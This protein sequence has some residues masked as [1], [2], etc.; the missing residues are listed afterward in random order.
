MLKM[1]TLIPFSDPRK[2]GTDENASLLDKDQVRARNLVFE[3]SGHSDML[4][5]L[6]GLALNP[7]NLKAP[8]QVQKLR[9][10]CLKVRKILFAESV[11]STQMKRK[12]EQLQEDT[13]SAVAYVSAE[14]ESDTP[15]FKKICEEKTS[16]ASSSVNSGDSADDNSYHL[17]CKL[18]STGSSLTLEYRYHEKPVDTNVTIVDG[19]KQYRYHE[20]PV[21][22]DVTFVDGAKQSDLYSTDGSRLIETDESV[23]GLNQLSPE[24]LNEPTMANFDDSVHGPEF[25]STDE[26]DS[27][28][29]KALKLWIS[30]GDNPLKSVS[31]EDINGST[32]KSE[33]ISGEDEDLKLRKALKLWLSNGRCLPKPVIPTGSGFQAEIPEWTGSTNRGNDDLRWLGTQIWPIKG[34]GKGNVVKEVGKGRPD[35]CSCISPRSA[36][37]VKRHIRE[38]SICLQSEIG[39]A[40]LSWKFDEMGE[41]VSKSWKVKEQ[42]AFKSLVKMNP[43]SNGTC[44]WE[45]ALKRFPSKCQKR[46]VSYYYNVFIPR[47]MSL[48]TRS[49]REEIDSDEDQVDDEAN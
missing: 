38:A 11:G 43:L 19:A 29:L 34:K 5:W 23:T 25:S 32:Y 45:L 10:Q 35:S 37:C 4:M 47:R 36:D 16:S 24:I 13:G 8:H 46:L 7:F 12:L 41:S 39:P 44:F 40:F 20:K 2:Q 15:N 30:K 28:L 48:Q 9:N 1:A 33:L 26:N 49:S 17:V 14:N 18:Q 21:D 27:L 3:S 31:M 22:T 6:K 42:Q